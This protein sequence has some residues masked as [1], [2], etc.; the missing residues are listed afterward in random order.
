MQKYNKAI[1][2]L[3]LGVAF[4]VL[5]EYGITEDTTLYSAL[6]TLLVAGGVYLIPNKG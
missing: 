1:I 5:K 2:A 6:E 3:I 4:T